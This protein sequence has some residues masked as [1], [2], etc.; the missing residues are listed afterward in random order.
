MS[1][2]DLTTQFP[3]PESRE[4]EALVVRE[5]DMMSRRRPESSLK[6]LRQRIE[7]LFLEIVEKPEVNPEAANYVMKF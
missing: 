4:L 1:V 2:R 5:I 6:G 7:T 3:F